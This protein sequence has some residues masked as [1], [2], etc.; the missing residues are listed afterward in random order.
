M[1]PVKI[2]LNC[3]LTEQ[4]NFFLKLSLDHGKGDCPGGNGAK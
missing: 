2:N 4:N 1:V 3:E